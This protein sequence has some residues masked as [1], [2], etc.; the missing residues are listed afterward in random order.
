MADENKNVEVE[1]NNQ[2]NG[3]DNG[4]AGSTGKENDQHAG[5]SGDNAKKSERTF[6]QEQVSKMM[7]KEKNQGRNAVFNELG[8]DPNDGKMVE[9]VKS[10]IASQKSEEQKAAEQQAQNAAKLAEAEAKAQQAECK[11]EAMVLGAKPEFVD[12]VIVLAMAKM[13]DDSDFKT[14]ISEIKTKYPN[15][16]GADTSSDKEDKNDKDSK[17]AT[18]KKGTGTSM[19]NLGKDDKSEDAKSMGSRLAA[20]R[21]SAPNKTSNFMKR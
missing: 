4:G 21:R 3:T 19:K 20:Q 1:N 13:S 9:L 7:A 6:T 2:D 18:G 5:A 16:F 8:I 14:I 15:F 12:D 17:N 11:A 10:L